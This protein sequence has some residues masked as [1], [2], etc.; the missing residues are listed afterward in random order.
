MVRDESETTSLLT[1]AD[2]LLEVPQVFKANGIQ[3][4]RKYDL[5]E[6]LE[7]AIIKSKLISQASSFVA[8]GCVS[9]SHIGDLQNAV[10][11]HDAA[12][13]GARYPP[14]V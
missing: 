12:N 9:E 3:T 11:F 5:L 14:V 7:L 6:T 4:L 13:C 10:Q 1:A 2:N 8:D